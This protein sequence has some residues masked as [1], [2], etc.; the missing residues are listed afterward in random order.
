MNLKTLIMMLAVLMLLSGCQT[1]THWSDQVDGVNFSMYQTYKIDEQC[2]DY[3]PGVN[4]INQQRIKNAIE[5][6]LRKIIN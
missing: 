5:K 6:E 1:L 2:S 4:P 3:N